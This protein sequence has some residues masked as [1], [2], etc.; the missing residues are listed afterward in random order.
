SGAGAVINSSSTKSTLFTGFDDTDSTFSRTVGTALSDQTRNGYVDLVKVGAGTLTVTGALT[1]SGGFGSY[2]LL[3]VTDATL[4]GN[5]HVGR[6]DPE[7]EIQAH[8]GR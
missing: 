3:R 7:H 2:G 1:F 8:T 6:S 5:G 4:V